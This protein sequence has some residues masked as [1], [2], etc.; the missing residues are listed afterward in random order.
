MH[1]I[2]IRVLSLLILVSLGVKAKIERIKVGTGSYRGD[3]YTG[4]DMLLFKK[5][6]LLLQIG[7]VLKDRGLNDFVQYS[8]SYQFNPE[9]LE[10]DVLKK[11]RVSG[12]VGVGLVYADIDKLFVELPNQYPDGYYIPTAIRGYFTVGVEIQLQHKI[13]LYVEYNALDI[14]V[15]GYLRNRELFFNQ[16][17]FGITDIGTFGVGLL[18][19]FR[20]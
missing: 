8:I 10:V 19:R 16:E 1:S 5:H 18:W 15:D 20:V 11:Y 12:Y 14:G 17:F 4:V 7:Y 9:I 6:H 13:E 2:L 3:I